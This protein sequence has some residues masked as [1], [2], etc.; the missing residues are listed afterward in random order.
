M[1]DQP[2]QLETAPP[3]AAPR[4][5]Q[6]PRAVAGVIFL[7]SFGLLA[8][9]AYLQPSAAGA[10][11]HQQLGL[12]PC[13]FLVSTGLPCATCGMTTSFSHATNGDFVAA[14]LTQPTGSLLALFTAMTAI[15]SGYATV[16]GMS[17]APIGRAIWRPRMVVLFV[18]LLLAGWTYKIFDTLLGT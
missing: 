8:V 18:T 1:Q 2:S 13:G 11:T 5:E 12:P 6:T 16:T 15:V 10:G 9:A 3:S 17:L 14:F 4:R 7:V